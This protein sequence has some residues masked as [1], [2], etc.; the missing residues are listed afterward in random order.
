MWEDEEPNGLERIV[1]G[2]KNTASAGLQ[3]IDEISARVYEAALRHPAISGAIVGI[4]HWIYGTA[5]MP[6]MDESSI[7]KIIA[8]GMASG[9]GTIMLLNTANNYHKEMEKVEEEKSLINDLGALTYHSKLTGVLA[10]GFTNFWTGMSTY[11]GLSLVRDYAH[12]AR[13][14]LLPQGRNSYQRIKNSILNNSR[15]AAIIGSV[16]IN[17]LS[18][19][20]ALGFAVDYLCIY[21]ALEMTRRSEFI[22]QGITDETKSFWNILPRRA[23]A[24]SAVAATGVFAFLSFTVPNGYTPIS[25]YWPELTV[26][27]NPDPILTEKPDLNFMPFTMNVKNDYFINLG[28]LGAFTIS[29]IGL[30]LLHTNSLRILKKGW[31]SKFAALRRDYGS[32][33]SR[34]EEILEIPISTQ[35]QS[36]VISKIG[37]IYQKK[38]DIARSM[39]QYIQAASIS[40]KKATAL[41]PLEFVTRLFAIDRIADI[42]NKDRINRALA[43]MR[44]KHFDRAR[45]EFQLEEEENPENQDLLCFHAYAL[46]LMEDPR[47]EEKWQKVI[48]LVQQVPA[49]RDKFRSIEGKDVYQ[50]TTSQFL[51]NTF[52]FKR[53]EREALEDEYKFMFP[54]YQEGLAVEPL[55]IVELSGDNFLITMHAPGE[56]LY[57]YLKRSRDLDALETT[58][59]FLAAMHASMNTEGIRLR[60]YREE[61]EKRLEANDP[62]LED[63]RDKIRENISATYDFDWMPLV[64]DRDAHPYNWFIDRDGNIIALDIENRGLSPPVF[65]LAK[66]LFQGRYIPIS[67]EGDQIMDDLTG[68][69]LSVFNPN[70]PRRIEDERRFSKALL[71]GCISR[72]ISYHCFAYDNPHTEEARFGF[73]RHGLHATERLIDEF[74]SSFSDS[75]LRQLEG[76]RDATRLL[77]IRY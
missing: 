59:N 2:V 35:M 36:E 52:V 42:F 12:K 7:M 68:K 15:L 56:R 69:Y 14:Y 16:G 9:I 10:G 53:G 54:L 22:R 45:Y 25:M 61:L 74:K 46:D 75:Q 70:S 24:V 63:I 51:E 34:L 40:T 23:D 17:V 37:Q 26:I 13:E 8:R 30:N 64:F 71:Q 43:S 57:D 62:R 44:F 18:E 32:A 60:R 48:S 65:D 58:T 50:I 6:G 55:D 28:A 19:G 66:L 47:A 77:V 21:T 29:N 72:A 27:P 73:V 33:I 49:T 76:L 20:T 11:L 3:K 38:G 4:P 67:K 1:M 31:Q 5:T 39:Q 41:S